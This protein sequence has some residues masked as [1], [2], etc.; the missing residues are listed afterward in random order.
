MATGTMSWEFWI[1]RG[2]TFTDFI[3][4]DARGRLH[5]AKLLSSD[6]APLSGIRRILESAGEIEPGATLPPCTVKLGSTVATNALLERRGVPTVLVTSRGLADVFQIGT[7][8]RPDLFALQIRKPAPLHQHS[9]EISGRRGVDGDEIEPFDPEAA[10]RA[11]EAAR[12]KGAASAAVVGMHAYADPELERR[13]VEIARAVGFDYVVASHEIAREMGFLARGETAVVDAYLTPLLRG[14]VARLAAGLPGSR[15]RFMQSS[16]G[17]SDGARF[18]GPTALLSGPAGGV[19][20]A[21]RVA[22]AAGCPRAIGF[23]M[24][25]TSTD[26]SLIV[27]GEVERA[28]ETVVG[29]VRVKAPML[30]IHSVASGGGSLCRFDGF[31]LTVGPESAGS[32]PGPLCYGPRKRG[33]A[34][35]GGQAADSS[36]RGLA[37]TDVNLALGRVQPDRFP[38]ALH[39]EPVT[40]A[41]AALR[42]RLQKAGLVM[43]ED[44]IA[45]GF[46]EVANAGMAQAIAQVSVARGVDPRDHVLVAFGGAAG[47]HVCAIARILGVGRILLHPLAGLLSAYGI[48]VAEVSWDGQRDAGRVELPRS[49]EELPPEI[50]T[51]LTE[52]AEE[53]MRALSEEGAGHELETERWLDLRYRGTDTPLSIRQPAEDDWAGAFLAE[54]QSRFGYV[55]EGHPIEIMTARVRARSAAAAVSTT[56][57]QAEPD[58]VPAA[59]RARRVEQAWF[60]GVGRVE[61]TVFDRESL[62]PGCEIDGPAIVLEDT[63]TVVIDPGFRARVDP[64]GVLDLVDTANAPRAARTDVERADPVRL[65]V[66]GNR[67]MS[68]AEQMGAVLRNTA[69]STNIK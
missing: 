57:P 65:E 48:G 15:L 1:D 29:G 38:F 46:V 20:A 13:V 34:E 2:G 32:D 12:D 4:R 22:A 40:R 6:D 9:V 60:P 47:Q 28:F 30:R 31:R 19:V 63:G 18:R 64:A 43:S 56:P 52:L 3:G 26:V 33:G 7:Q 45:S 27:G 5:T 36:D 14:H 24:G 21:A 41:L 10:Q 11:L 37:L 35:D 55:R 68:I 67:F 25:G 8:E 69:V 54:H 66:F 50:E 59:P 16:G 42:G 51:A 49:G 61:T 39:R 44:E 58:S 53:G 17:L 62:H 23:D